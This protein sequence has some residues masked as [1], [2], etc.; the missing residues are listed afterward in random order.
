M[1]PTQQDMED[2]ALAAGYKLENYGHD[3]KGPVMMVAF[4]HWPPTLWMPQ[5]MP[6]HAIRLMVDAGIDLISS[7]VSRTVLASA[8]SYIGTFRDEDRHVIIDPIP[9]GE[10]KHAATRKAIFQAAVAKGRAIREAKN[11]RR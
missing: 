9:Y 5:A 11:D 7:E 10:D 2:A 6:G 4:D 3:K 8:T 1:T